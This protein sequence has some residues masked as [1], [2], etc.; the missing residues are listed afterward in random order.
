MMMEYAAVGSCILM[1][2][3]QNE[4]EK[5]I[6]KKAWT[7][8]DILNHG[9]GWN[10]ARWKLLLWPTSWIL[11]LIDKVSLGRV[12]KAQRLFEQVLVNTYRKIEEKGLSYLCLDQVRLRA[13]YFTHLT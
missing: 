4:K 5:G 2:G 10:V 6:K 3:A 7:R 12:L 13:S 1:I 11:F 8:V 9:D